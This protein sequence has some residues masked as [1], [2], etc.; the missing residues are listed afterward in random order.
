[1]VT[2]LSQITCDFARIPSGLFCRYESKAIIFVSGAEADRTAGTT[3]F[4]DLSPGFVTG[5]RSIRFTWHQV[6]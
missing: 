6:T 5:E 3:A 1:M 2:K 4:R